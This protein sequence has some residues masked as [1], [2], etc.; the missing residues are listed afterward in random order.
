MSV[1]A[2][3]LVA[4]EPAPARKTGFR[5]RFAR[6]ARNRLA[7]AGAICLLALV[8]VAVLAPWIVPYPDD[9]AD[10]L[11]FDA[12]LQSPSLAHPMGTD[13]VGRDVLTRVMAG[14]R[15][16][17]SMAAIV[18]AIAV[19]IGVPLGLFAGYY[20][21]ALEQVLM[22]ITDG[23]SAVPALVLALAITVL[24][25]PSLINAM[26]AIGFVWWRSFAR[27]A[28]GQTLSRKQETYVTVARSLGASDLLIMFREIL[29]NISSPLLV[30]ISLNAGYAVL[31]GTALSFLGAG[32]R[33]PTPEWGQMV[34]ASRN[35]LP[36]AWWPSLFPG[37][38]IFIT[39]VSFNLLGDGLRDY[40]SEE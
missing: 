37:I 13:E 34:A 8:V 33:P 30:A 39:V 28:H 1:S 27:I 32:A 2:L 4:E 40:F 29:P 9:V 18:L 22:R 25:G 35:Y 31:T 7:L 6:F 17:L 24:L 20:G 3:D 5:R 11:N 19:T 12:V 23:F 36:G 38:A 15:W 26:I 16:S 10:S 14:A 21:G